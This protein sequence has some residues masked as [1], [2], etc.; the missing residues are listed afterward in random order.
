MRTTD[1]RRERLRGTRLELRRGEPDER[2]L[3]PAE[4]LDELERRF[5]V[6]V[7]DDDRAATAQPALRE[8]PAHSGT[9]RST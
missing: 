5:G 3:T 8:L 6:A 4:A 2:T 9:L 1:D 7:D